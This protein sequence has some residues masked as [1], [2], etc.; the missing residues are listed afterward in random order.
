MAENIA[1]LFEQFSRIIPIA[2]EAMTDF[3]ES[4]TQKARKDVLH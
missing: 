1:G 4:N 3:G 2:G